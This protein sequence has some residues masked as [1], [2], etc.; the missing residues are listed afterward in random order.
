MQANSTPILR[1][2]ASGWACDKGASSQVPS[3]ATTGERDT[4]EPVHYVAYS[5]HSS[6]R[7]LE[8]FIRALTPREAPS[9]LLA[10]RPP[11]HSPPLPPTKHTL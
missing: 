4:E 11:L 1:I 10:Y 7:E 8:S 5:S 2:V 3:V 6:F 9:T